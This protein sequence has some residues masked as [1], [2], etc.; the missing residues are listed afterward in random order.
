MHCVREVRGRGQQLPLSG[1]RGESVTEEARA[2]RAEY[3]R[4]YRKT[5]TGAERNR[6]AQARYWKKKSMENTQRATEADKKE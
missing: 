1:K 2:A 5:E 3:M 4:R 6:E